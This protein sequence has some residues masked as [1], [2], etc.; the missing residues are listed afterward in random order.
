MI[1][2][3]AVNIERSK[4]LDFDGLS[5][6]LGRTLRGCRPQ[7][8]QLGARACTEAADPLLVLNAREVN[9]Q[10]YSD[11]YYD[12]H[13][14]HYT[15]QLKTLKGWCGS[16]HFADKVLHTDF[17]HTCAGHPVYI[18][19]ADNYEDLRERFGKTVENFR[20]L[21][22]LEPPRVLTFAL[23]RGIFSREIFQRIVADA[24][25]HL[26]TWE[27]DYKRGPWRPW[28]EKEVQGAFLASGR[29]AGSFVL[30]A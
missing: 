8:L 3:G 13:T 23:D 29:A 15:G 18:A 24:C 27:K 26:V 7:R 9:A 28:N 5:V 11:F 2:L 6:M 25:F 20:N 4:L 22:N 17:I 14:K 12:A 30:Q 1:F 19:Y 21:L 16:K 10:N